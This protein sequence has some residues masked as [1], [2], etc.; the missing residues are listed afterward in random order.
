MATCTCQGIEKPAAL[1]PQ[2]T[3]PHITSAQIKVSIIFL[4]LHPLLD[5]SVADHTAYYSNCSNSYN[6]RIR[7]G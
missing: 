2:N 1:V 4:G 3:K 6:Y 7:F 5:V